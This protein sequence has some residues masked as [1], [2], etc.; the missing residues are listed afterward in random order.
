M[1]PMNQAE[2]FRAFPSRRSQYP[3]NRRKK[4]TV[5]VCEKEELLLSGKNVSSTPMFV[6]TSRNREEER[7]R[8]GMATGHMGC[9]A[10]Q[11]ARVVV[12]TSLYDDRLTISN[13][14]NDNDDELANERSGTVKPR[15]CRPSPAGCLTR[16]V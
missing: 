5:P 15:S 10:L 4:E 1:A 11:P 3:K 13:D 9:T 7:Q 16:F 12:L 14:D 6:Q 8:E 2:S